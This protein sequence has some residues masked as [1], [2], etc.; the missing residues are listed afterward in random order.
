MPLPLSGHRIGGVLNNKL[1][2]ALQH[3]LSVFSRNIQP[4]FEAPLN[5]S[6]LLY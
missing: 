3:A 4:S 6:R 1:V 5:D 2:V